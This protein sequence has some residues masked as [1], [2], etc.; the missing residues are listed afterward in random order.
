[1]PESPVPF[2]AAS[3]D[4]Q[5]LQV[6]ADAKTEAQ[7]PGVSLSDMIRSLPQA[8]SP[9]IDELYAYTQGDITLMAR[10]MWRTATERGGEIASPLVPAFG[11]A[12]AIAGL[13]RDNYPATFRLCTRVP[14]VESALQRQDADTLSF[15]ALGDTGAGS[16]HAAACMAYAGTSKFDKQSTT[17][18]VRLDH[19]V[20]TPALRRSLLGIH[21]FRE[22]VV[23]AEVLGLQTVEML[24]RES[25]SYRGFKPG[26]MLARAIVGLGYTVQDLGVR[27]VKG[28]GDQAECIFA[29]R[30]SQG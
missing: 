13:M 22:L 25:T 15:L 5:L 18:V 16:I 1:M 19:M 23:R 28:E 30:M 6:Y 2:S 4:L 11:R 21:M 7:I 20:V 10:E 27:Q 17:E 29:I 14:S 9:Y 8:P 26:S 24:T 3:T 12:E